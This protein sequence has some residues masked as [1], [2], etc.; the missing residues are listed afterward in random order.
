MF[1]NDNNTCKPVLAIVR[2]KLL[3]TIP[4]ANAGHEGT[5]LCGC[6]AGDAHGEG[7]RRP[8][9]RR[10]WAIDECAKVKRPK[11]LGF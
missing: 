4:F 1:G 3:I 11:I 7:R 2:G 8:E 9:G 6:G 5:W 10:V